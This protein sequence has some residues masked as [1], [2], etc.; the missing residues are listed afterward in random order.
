MS[1]LLDI[2][3]VQSRAHG[4]RGIARYLLE[5]AQALERVAPE[6]L[7]A[8]VLNPH[9]AV[10]GTLEPLTH[11]P[12]LAFADRVDVSSA[13]AYHIGSPIELDVALDD[14]WPPHVRQARLPLVVTLYDVI[15]LVFPMTYLSD[16][17]PRRRYLARL[18]LFRRAERIL[19]ISQASADDAADL[20]GIPHKR[21]R[22]VGTGVSAAFAPAADRTAAFAALHEKLPAVE[23]RYILF[24]G[25]IEPRKNIDRLL[26]AYSLLPQRVQD[27]HQ[28][29][30]VCRVEPETRATLAERLRELEI[31]DRVLFTGFVPDD[32]LVLLY[33]ATELFVFPSLYEGFGLPIAEALACGAPVIAARNS[34]LTELVDEPAALFD[35]R[36]VRSI[37]SAL[38][39]GLRNPALRARLLEKKLDP[40]YRWN[41]V[42]ER[43]AEVYQE[44]S[45]LRRAPARPRRRERI[46]FVTP[47]PPHLSGVA[48][49]SYRLIEALTRLCEVDA[50]LDAEEIEARAPAGV[51]LRPARTLPIVEAGLGGYDQVFYCLGNS[52]FHAEALALLRQRSGVVIAHDVRLSGLYAW[53]ARNTPDVVP[54]GFHATLHR[55]YSDRLPPDVGAEGHVDFWTA[56]RYGIYMAQEAIARSQRFVVHSEH[57]ARLA[58]LDALP[59]DAGRVDV[60]PYAVINPEEFDPVEPDGVV[61]VG[62]FGI[63]SATKQPEK[64]VDAW[65][66]V[67][68]EL[69][70]AKLAFVGSDA[71]TGE[72]ERIRKR[73]RA[74]GVEDALEQTGPLAEAELRK[75]ITK[76]AL[77]VQLRAASSG[78]TS[79][80]I[81][82][83]MSAG[84]PTI[85]TRLGSAA[86]LPDAA[87]VK[88]AR[89]VTPEALGRQIV[90]LLRDPERRTRLGAAAT[91]FARSNSFDHVARILFE[92]YVR[93]ARGARAA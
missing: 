65:K 80:V 78:E 5:L 90:S 16:P 6:L 20:L 52:E 25:G 42:A 55:M 35:P 88:V 1:V 46:A 41:A 91:A 7:Q 72:N 10:P 3:G 83:C 89:D 30:I 53:A 59:G 77:A 43:T 68:C 4:E 54:D 60:I 38:E 15:P 84:V 32:E 51:E 37:T 74:V 47:L 44:I 40:R 31:H 17:V 57:A 66:Y 2:Q 85:V 12:K 33:Q 36:S 18:E 70:D 56:D 61:R 69:P 73:A 23:P 8:Y 45:T 48:D 87:T 26:V 92:R 27:A 22:V 11:T 34:A 29:V 62:T 13:T 24:T 79:A 82:R 28:L 49:E 9:L 71:G 21:L 67:S 81:A 14:L 19:A 64:L 76:S 93:A 58:R 75:W 39:R 63:V 86:E 50:F